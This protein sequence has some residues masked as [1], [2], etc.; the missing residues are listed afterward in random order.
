[1]RD[2][3]LLNMI[4]YTY[5]A[6]IDFNTLVIKFIKYHVSGTNLTMALVQLSRRGRSSF[7]IVLTLC[8]AKSIVSLDY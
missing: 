2:G 5:H 7:Q 4:Y 8:Q 6:F 3:K 1:M